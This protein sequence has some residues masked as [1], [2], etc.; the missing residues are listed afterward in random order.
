DSLM[1][2]TQGDYARFNSNT[3]L[4]V[5]ED[6]Q[7]KAQ[8][9]YRDEVIAHEQT[10]QELL[11]ANKEKKEDEQKIKE[12]TQRVQLLEENQQ[13]RQK[14][15]FERKVNIWGWIITLFIAGI[16]YLFLIVG[17]EIAKTQFADISWKS[18]YGITG[19]FIATVIAGILYTKIKALCFRKVRQY[20][21]S[22]VKINE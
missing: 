18:V 13:N 11:L 1:D 2:I 7:S 20:L 21:Q 5:Y 10:R 4:E 17:I 6:I 9:Q 16:P 8:K 14:K 22:H 19:A 12:L 3:Y 15:E